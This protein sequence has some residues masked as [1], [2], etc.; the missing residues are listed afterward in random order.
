MNFYKVVELEKNKDFLNDAEKFLFKMIEKE[1]GYGY[2][3]EYHKDIKNLDEVYLSDDR[4]NF[5]VAIDYNNNI[6]GT[7]AIR[8]YDK[9]FSEFKGVYCKKTTAS[10]WRL[11]V[12]EKYRRLGI[13]SELVRK[14]E[15]F[16]KEKNYNKLYL[17]THKNITGALDFWLS[18]NY[19]ITIDTNNGFKT[20]HMDKNMINELRFNINKIQY[21]NTSIKSN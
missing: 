9:N 3:P 5:F 1:Y 14:V 12:D 2:N 7:I 18:Q 4:N 19:N 20:V 17:H 6:I 13:A 8:G 16:S 10:I 15:D 21:P 11:F